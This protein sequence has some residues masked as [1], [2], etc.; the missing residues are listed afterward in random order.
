MRLEETAV[1]RAL[2]FT[3]GGLALAG[4]VCF[5]YGVRDGSYACGVSGAITFGQAFKTFYGLFKK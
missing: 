5:Y 4:A 3:A 1:K 2:T